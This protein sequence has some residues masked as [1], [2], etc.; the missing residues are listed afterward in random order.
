MDIRLPR[1]DRKRAP[2]MRDGLVELPAEAQ[3]EREVEMRISV[4]WIGGNRPLVLSNGLVLL[5]RCLHDVTEIEIDAIVSGLESRG[6]TRLAHS[7]G[8]PT[9]QLKRHSQIAVC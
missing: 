8:E 3:D 4:C 7:V 2:E 5:P 9:L 6:F 1:V